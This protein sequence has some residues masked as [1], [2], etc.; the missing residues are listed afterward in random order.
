MNGRMYDPV[1]GKM[2][3]PDIYVQSIY[4]TQS[5]NRYSYVTNN[6]LIFTDPSGYKETLAD[7]GVT[8]YRLSTASYDFSYL[9]NIGE[10][11]G[12]FMGNGSNF[13]SY[14]S[15]KGEQR[16]VG[17]G[18]NGKNSSPKK[19]ITF[20]IHINGKVYTYAL[21]LTDEQIQNIKGAPDLL[22]STID[23]TLM[24]TDDKLSITAVEGAEGLSKAFAVTSLIVSGFDMQR[25]N[26][27]RKS[28]PSLTNYA[29]QN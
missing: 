5:Y 9:A 8:G 23:L 12:E 14:T 22:G 18:G 19:T 28:S 24:L 20:R 29:G 6:P 25:Q 2:L 26:F 4:S 3:A 27:L 21:T 16:G 15:P 10:G 13:V 17:G 11:M 1:I 7:V